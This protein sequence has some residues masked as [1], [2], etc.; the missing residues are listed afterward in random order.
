MWHMTGNWESHVAG[1]CLAAA[2]AMKVQGLA[3]A[4]EVEPGTKPCLAPVPLDG[5]K[6][7]ACF[8]MP[9]CLI[10]ELLALLWQ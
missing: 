1:T 7:R 6:C 4:D 3:G 9:L 8:S 2:R 5:P 10:V